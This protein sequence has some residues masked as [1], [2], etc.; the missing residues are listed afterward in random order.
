[1]IGAVG[2]FKIGAYAR[3]KDGTGYIIGCDGGSYQIVSTERDDEQDYSSSEL[4]PW[5]PSPGER[6]IEADNED[7]VTGVVVDDGEGT[8]MVMWN[9]FFE[10]QTWP[11]K[12]LEP[13]W[14]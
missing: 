4:T 8:S 5:L 14:D 13:A 7:C 2:E 3:T 10:P 1:M 9:G 11:N 12:N 6:V